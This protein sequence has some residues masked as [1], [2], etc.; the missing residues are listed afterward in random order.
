MSLDRRLR[1][2][3]DRLAADIEP[4]VEGRLRT[5]LERGHRPRLVSFALPIATATAAVLLVALV[6]PALLGLLRGEPGAPGGEPTPSPA[7]PSPIG[8]YAATVAAG[9]PAVDEHD[10]SGAWTIELEANGVLSVTAPSGFA[11][12]RTGY[13]YAITGD[14][15]TTDLFGSDVCSTLL[16]GSYTW[17]LAGEFL[18]LTVVDES[19]A[20]RAALLAGQEWQAVG[21]AE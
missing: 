21:A 4:D 1:D 7:A 19:C 9:D 11:G 10:L 3:L 2:G 17:E 15:L 20:G 12:T 16:P 8:A 5:T 14:R 6:G 18:R 13:S